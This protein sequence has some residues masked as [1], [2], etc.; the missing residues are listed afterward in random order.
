[1]LP[2]ESVVAL[3][4]DADD[5]KHALAQVDQQ[6]EATAAPLDHA[7][8]HRVRA[9][10]AQA[11][12]AAAG[13][14][15]AGQATRS[16]FDAVA[17][18]VRAE[19]DLPPPPPRAGILTD[20]VVWATTPVRI[21]FAGGWS[22]T[23]PI[24][25][26]QGGAV[27]NAAVTLN[28]Q[29]PV[30]VM[31]KLSDTP[32]I[33]LSSIDLGQRVVIETSRQLAGAIDATQWH[34]LPVAALRLAGLL[35]AKP[36]ASL[37]RHL[38]RFGGGLDITLFSALPKGSGMGTSSILGA[39]MLACLARVTGQPLDQDAVIARTSLLEQIMGTGGGWQDQVGGITPGIKLIRTRPG[40]DQSPSI[41]WCAADTPAVAGLDDR[42]LLYFTGIKRM[43]R[44]ILQKVVL[45]YLAR[46]PGLMQIV[47]E[48]KTEAE[49]LKRH[50]D[51]GDADAL[52]RGVERYWQLKRAIDPGSTNPR[53]EALLE[54]VNRYLDARLLPGAGGGGFVF[55]IAKD[56]DAA[57]TVRR[58]LSQAPPNP[59]S[60]L[61]DFRIDRQGLQVTTL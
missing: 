40:P 60:R 22:D 58:V 15:F 31:A 51:A 8:L 29:Y 45:R 25:T 54:P 26:E 41:H 35:P 33:T 50:L 12:P 49:H 24:C 23:P 43:A 61:F 39:A 30:Q 53:I 3:L 37:K 1:M 6:I 21:D 7:R 28:G 38:E 48:L 16:A 57:A 20:Q 55:M 59:L 47:D 9:A 5:A 4:R 42:A 2:A 46:D 13:K 56:P 32:A 11:Q 36:D 52:S 17:E 34:A 10:I 19:I 14:R 18:S 27:I 44:D